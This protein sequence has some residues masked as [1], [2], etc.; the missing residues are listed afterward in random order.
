VQAHL[1]AAEQVQRPAKWKRPRAPRAGRTRA[2]AR[3]P[4]ARCGTSSEN[5]TSSS[6]KRAC[7]PRPSEPY[8]PQPSAATTRWHGTNRPKRFTAQTGPDR[9]LRVRVAR[10]RRD[11]PVARRLAV[12]DRAHRLHGR[13]LERRAPVEVERDVHEPSH[14]PRKVLADPVDERVIS[15][16]TRRPR[17]TAARARRRGRPRSTSSPPPQPPP[18]TDSLD[19]RRIVESGA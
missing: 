4:R 19:H 13:A 1:A 7:N 3:C 10:E 15:G 14:E 9:P 6:S 12:R 11:L 2:P 18:R 8:D 17:P 5:D 16:P